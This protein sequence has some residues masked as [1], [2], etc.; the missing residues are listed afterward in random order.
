MDSWIKRFASKRPARE[1]KKPEYALVRCGALEPQAGP[2]GAVWSYR[3]DVHVVS[4]SPCL[5]FPPPLR[6]SASIYKTRGRRR[7][8]T[9]HVA[10]TLGTQ[11]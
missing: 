2:G 7:S 5:S 1:K 9:P 11:L 4:S 3:V 6:A 8:L 10:N